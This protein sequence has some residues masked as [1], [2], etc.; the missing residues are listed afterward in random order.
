MSQQHNPSTVVGCFAGTAANYAQ[1]RPSY[2]PVVIKALADRC[3]LDRTGHIL[4]IGCGPGLLTLPLSHMA[5]NV[6]AIDVDEDMIGIA[7]ANAEQADINN[8]VFRLMRGEDISPA[9]GQVKAAIFGNSFH[10]MNRTLVVD[11]LHS[12]LTKN[13]HIAVL[14]G[15]YI[16]H[17]NE[18]W[19]KPVRQTIIEFTGEDRSQG[20]STSL[21][22]VD[23]LAN[24]GY[25]EIK[26][27]E[28]EAPQSYSL[29]ELLGFLASTSYASHRKLGQKTNEFE[30]I[31]RERLKNSGDTYTEMAKFIL[32]TAKQA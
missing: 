25:I 19:K 2:P 18:E 24:A 29:S 22:D 7:Q 28:Y 32:V 14:T 9:L 23:V 31:L 10:W 26:T 17:G 11:K 30:R 13:G 5:D 12:L 4:E 15:F 16:W 27:W 20:M 8:V 1:Y 6:T 3:C 21:P